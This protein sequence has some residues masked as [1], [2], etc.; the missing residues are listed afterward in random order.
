MIDVDELKVIND[1]FGH[2]AGDLVIKDIAEI[3][4]RSVRMF[5]VCARFGGDEFAIIMPG[6]AAASAIRIAERIRQRIESYLPSV[7][8]LQSHRVTASI[9]LAIST[10]DMTVRDLIAHADQ[11]LYLAKREGKNRVRV[12]KEDAGLNANSDREI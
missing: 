4:R 10:P 11:A 1:S 5:D 7:R 12:L 3:L 9:G 2:L 8:P 6:S